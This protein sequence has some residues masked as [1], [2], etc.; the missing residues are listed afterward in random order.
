MCQTVATD[1]RAGAELPSGAMAT[2]PAITMDVAMAAVCVNV[3]VFVLIGGVLSTLVGAWSSLDPS[4]VMVGCARSS[5]TG[6]D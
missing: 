5:W 6:F 2:P 1:L 3:N 4:R